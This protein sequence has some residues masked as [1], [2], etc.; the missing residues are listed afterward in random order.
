M[1]N[2]RQVGI[3]KDIRSKKAIV[4]IGV[5]PITVN[6]EDLVMVKEK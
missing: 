5:I 2:T 6:L 4:Q 3:V 1:K